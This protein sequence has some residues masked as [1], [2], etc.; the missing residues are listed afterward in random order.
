MKYKVSE[1]KIYTTTDY[2]KFVFTDWNRNISNS[3]VVLMVESITKVGW[4]PQPILVNEKFEIIDGQSRVMAL[5]QLGMPVEFIIMPGIG[6][7]EC[8]A[9]NLFQKNW[10]TKNYIDS[11][12][13]DNN[14]HYIWLKEV[15]ARYSKALTTSVVIN[16]A[17]GKGRSYIL[18]GQKN[19]IVNDGRFKLSPSEKTYVENVLFY[20]SRF[21]DTIDYV[22]GRKETFFGAI[23]F[24][25]QLEELDRERIC[26]V[27]NDARYDGLVSSGTV[28]GWLQ[29][30][31]TLY[32]K[33]LQKCSRVDI[34][35]EYKIA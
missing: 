23:M 22:G 11:Y 10:T 30:I 32:N 12:V 3:R 21:S 20:L 4:L 26:K 34:V 2:D 9:L 6:R 27:I 18:G 31:E 19:I 28:E 33:R 15:I 13:A 16:V 5:K 7:K 35:H 24:L 14:E 1:K 17:I 25:Y 29:Q 8:Q